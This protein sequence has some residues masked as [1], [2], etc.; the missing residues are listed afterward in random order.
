MAFVRGGFRLAAPFIAAGA[1]AGALVFLDVIG[2]L[3]PVAEVRGYAGVLPRPVWLLIS[4]AF[5]AFGAFLLFTFR[6]P[7]RPVGRS[8]VS[9]AD[10]VVRFA[11][12]RGGMLHIS[13]FLGLHNVHIV[14]APTYGPVK[15]VVRQAGGHVPAY[16][17]RS[18]A[19]ERVSV[20]LSAPGGTAIV[21]MVA[22]AFARRIVP[23]V[24]EGDVMTKGDKIGF[25]RFGS[26]V[27]LFLP[28][29]YEPNVVAGSRVLAGVT[30]VA[31]E[32][33]ERAGEGPADAWLMSVRR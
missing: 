1:V 14:R 12:V 13:I 4:A 24:G 25:I 27:D 18:S 19:N 23:Y 11:G 2:S 10:G 32:S 15:A 33:R 7:R 16:S 3:P 22:G 5:I 8:V 31:V 29:T 21:T 28:G 17:G 30:T 20:T 9:P 6:D 26:R